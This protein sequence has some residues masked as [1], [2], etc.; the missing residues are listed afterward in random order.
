MFLFFGSFSLYGVVSVEVV[1]C[2]STRVA[3]VYAVMS[4]EY[5]FV[6]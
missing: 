2:E 1:S 4:Y 3:S 5:M 6:V